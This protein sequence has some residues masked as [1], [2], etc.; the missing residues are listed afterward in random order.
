MARAVGEAGSDDADE[1]R[2]KGEVLWK[3]HVQCDRLLQ[4]SSAEEGCRKN[5]F[6]KKIS[7]AAVQWSELQLWLRE[8]G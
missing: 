1:R 2:G 7:V 6:K 8:L 4:R 5:P 3:T